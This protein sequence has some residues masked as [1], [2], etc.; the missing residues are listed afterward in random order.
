MEGSE[1][2][3]KMLLG[4]E[5]VRNV[6]FAPDGIVEVVYPVESNE[7]VLGLNMYED[8]LGNWEARAAI[9]EKELYMAGPFVTWNH[10][11]NQCC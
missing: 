10:T 2:I 3:A 8:G 6:L 1:E 9:A 4:D 5:G 7:K 11:G